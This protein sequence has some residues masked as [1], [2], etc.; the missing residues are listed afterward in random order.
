MAIHSERTPGDRRPRQHEDRETQG[1][2]VLLV[3][4]LPGKMSPGP[5]VEPPFFLSPRKGLILQTANTVNTKMRQ[6]W[7]GA[8]LL[9]AIKAA[10]AIEAKGE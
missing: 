9:Y 10:A 2:F 1:G 8:P 5:T 3:I 4:I 6:F 7:Q